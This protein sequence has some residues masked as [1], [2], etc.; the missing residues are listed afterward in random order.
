MAQCRGM[1]S[2]A[3]MAASLL[4]KMNEETVMMTLDAMPSWHGMA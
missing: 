3:F 4:L 2:S 1:C